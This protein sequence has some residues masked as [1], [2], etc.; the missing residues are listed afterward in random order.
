[1]VTDDDTV[2]LGAE[3]QEVQASAFLHIAVEGGLLYVEFVSTVL[4]AL[5]PAFRNMDYLPNETGNLLGLAARGTLMYTAADAVMAPLHLLRDLF[6]VAAVSRRMTK[7][8]RL[9]RETPAYNYGARESVRELA[10]QAG[11]DTYT[12]ELDAEKYSRI[13]LHRINDAVLDFLAEHG[14]DT[15]EYRAQAAAVT[16]IGSTIN[17]SVAVGAAATANT[18][19]TTTTGTAG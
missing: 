18:T 11:P 17:G 3:D 8:D 7:A 1:M 13:L 16:I 9:R 10:A 12:R 14:V 2:L 5:R 6:Q 19:T 4:G 15:S